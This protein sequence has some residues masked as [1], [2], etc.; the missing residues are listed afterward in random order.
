MVAGGVLILGWLAWAALNPA[1]APYSYALVAQ[2]KPDEFPELKL[3][4]REQQRISVEKYQVRAVEG[5]TPAT[6]AYVAHADNQPPT[7]LA[8]TS[9][10]VEPLLNLSGSADDLNHLSRAVV[11]HGKPGARVLGWWDTSRQLQLLAGAHVVFG[12]NLAT[13]I[14]LP[15]AWKA[16]RGA[17]EAVERSFWQVPE[18]D[19]ESA[20]FEAYVDAL[21]S[22]PAAGMEKLRRLVGLDE[23]YL[24]V[25]LYDAYKLGELH[26][27]RFGIGYKDFPNTGFNHGLIRRVKG[28][29]K[30]N[31]YASYA[32][33]EHDASTVRVYFLTDS[34]STETLI[35]KLLPFSTS[36]PLELEQPRVV[37]QH[38]LYWVY[39]FPQ[40]AN[41]QPTEDS[42][43]M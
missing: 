10:S 1:P 32:V 24:V 23:A 37:F 35:A 12:Q 17:I 41:M 5:S 31:G 8:W 2:G 25:H 13:P 28:W 29:L 7:M 27:D 22:E 16:R 26:P 21:L 43:V 34:A 6:F 9:D 38:G 15:D 20:L 30:E 36:N 3:D 33:E 11:E 18:N 40:V 19:E 14:L 42:T 4:D 39:E